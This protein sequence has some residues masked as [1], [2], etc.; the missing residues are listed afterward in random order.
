MK[1]SAKIENMAMETSCT[2]NVTSG[3]RSDGIVCYQD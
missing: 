3:G 2:D 1:L